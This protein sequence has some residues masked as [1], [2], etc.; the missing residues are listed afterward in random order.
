M[1]GWMT[2]QKLMVGYTTRTI[3]IMS[4]TSWVFSP[5]APEWMQEWDGYNSD[6]FF[7]GV[8]IKYVDDGVRRIYHRNVHRIGHEQVI[9]RYE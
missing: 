6:S 9:D 1:I 2:V 5:R 7:S 3:G 4:A 8:L